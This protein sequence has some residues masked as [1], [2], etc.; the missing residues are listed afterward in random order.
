[1]AMVV[2]C[3][4]LPLRTFPLV[5]FG[6]GINLKFPSPEVRGYKCGGNAGIPVFRQASFGRPPGMPQ[7]RHP[8]KRYRDA[9]P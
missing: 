8:D 4:S 2:K 9:V 7:G 3:A 5:Q 6:H 1:M